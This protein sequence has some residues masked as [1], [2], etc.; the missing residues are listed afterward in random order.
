MTMMHLL[1]IKSMVKNQQ[2]SL[3][4][5]FIDHLRKQKE[6]YYRVN[7]NDFE[8]WWRLRSNNIGFEKVLSPTKTLLAMNARAPTNLPTSTTA[9]FQHQE[10]NG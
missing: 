5:S 3:T 6:T 4:E 2:V 10:A 7:Q 8:R 1:T 9:L